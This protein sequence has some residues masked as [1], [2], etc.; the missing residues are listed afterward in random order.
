MQENSSRFK[1][2]FKGILD[3]LSKHL[4]SNEE[5]F[6]RE[7]LQNGKDAITL[8]QL[9][10]SSF[11]LGKIAVEMMNYEDKSVLIFE[12]NGNGLTLDEVNSFLSVIGSSSKKNLSD[13]TA[14]KNNFV[15]QFGIGLLSCFM[16]S[17]KITLLTKSAASPKAVKWTASIEGTYVAEELADSSM[18][19]GTKIFLELS[20]KKRENYTADKIKRL[21]TKYSQFL[22]LEVNFIEDGTRQT[23]DRKFLPKVGNGQNADEIL[24][25][26][27]SYFN[28]NFNYFIPLKSRDGKTEGI[29]YIFPYS[30]KPGS[31]AANHIY[32]KN[33][34]IDE[35]CGD[36]LPEW[37]FFLK[38]VVNS[39]SLRPTASR[40]GIYKDGVLSATKADFEDCIRQY[41][42]DLAEKAP[43]ILE[44]I[45]NNHYLAVKS[46]A[47]TDAAFFDLIIDFISF[48]T[49]FGRMKAKEL[50]THEDI[51]YVEDIDQY[52][53]I[54]PIAKANGQMIVNTGYIYDTYLMKKMAENNP[55]KISLLSDLRFTDIMEKITWEEEN[56]YTSFRER[57]D[58]VLS[59]FSCKTS[60]RKFS[61][62]SLPAMFHL[63]SEGAFS[64][65][66]DRTK[67]VT[68]DLWG[69]LLGEFA[70]KDSYRQDSDLFLNMDNLLIKK[71]TRIEEASNFK[72]CVEL[73]YVNALL[74]GHYAL[75]E[76]ETSLLNQ[77]LIEII[78]LSIA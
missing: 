61:P 36:I 46:F 24:E 47:T 10:D 58:E 22:D 72:R 67:K 44:Q 54:L 23:I 11:S 18:E 29:G 28:I 7:L 69:G 19:T 49:S 65:D 77:N 9:K 45:I 6:L 15:G 53:Q 63:K 48:E 71:I 60:L 20:T 55:H 25:F 52:R 12:D 27:R 2:N 42:A 74:L 56:E 34:L 33:M 39:E 3:I 66:I 78:D 57:C 5:V 21:L 1:V 8:R 41:F 50:L 17:D 26:G 37:S 40:E 59:D 4:Y 35:A 75:N 30:A 32:I 73:I 13:I 68:D 76:R 43:S 38:A 64:R 51:K 16:V 70:S 31:Q 14:D 62:A